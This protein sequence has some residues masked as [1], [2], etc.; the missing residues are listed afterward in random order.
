MCD[1]WSDLLSDRPFLP[2]VAPSWRHWTPLKRCGCRS[3]NMKKTEH[4]PS[5]GRPSNRGRRPAIAPRTALKSPPS[6]CRRVPYSCTCHLPVPLHH[7]LSTQP[8]LN[9][10][11]PTAPPPPPPREAHTFMC[12]SF[13][14]YL[15]FHSPPLPPPPPLVLPAVGWRWRHQTP[16]TFTSR[17]PSGYLRGLALWTLTTGHAI[18]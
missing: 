11:Q 2:A 14:I 8:L 5:T 16:Q 10:C 6:Y 9:H 7:P 15:L 18:L 17:G 3:G 1:V 4:V 12:G 13:H